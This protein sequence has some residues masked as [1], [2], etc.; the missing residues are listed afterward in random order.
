MAKNIQ[1][2]WCI[3]G[4]FNAVLKDSERKGGS[5]PSACVRGD[6]AFKEFVLECY[7]LDMG[8]QGAP[9]T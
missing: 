3:M 8:Y 4:D 7:L 9:F 1:N 5:R 6:N 2:P